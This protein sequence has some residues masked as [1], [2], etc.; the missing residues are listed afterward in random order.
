MAEVI[1]FYSMSFEELVALDVVWFCKLYNR[2]GQVEARRQ[3]SWLPVY[4]VPHMEQAAGIRSI[5]DLH[6]RAQGTQTSPLPNEADQ[7]SIDRGWSRLR[8]ANTEGSEVGKLVSVK[9]L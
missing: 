6:K 2:I 8:T 5:R 4:S 1:A 3:I 7:V 9:R